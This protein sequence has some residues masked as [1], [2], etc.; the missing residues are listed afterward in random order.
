VVAEQFAKEMSVMTLNTFNGPPSFDGP[1]YEVHAAWNTVAR[2]DDYEAAQA[3]V[4]R[5]SDDGFP[6]ASLS[7]V[8]NGLRLVE[9]VTGRLTK[10]KAAASGAASGAWF[11]VLI[12]LLLTMFTTG[13]AVLSLLAAGVLFGAAWGALFGFLA[14]AATRGR[15]DFSAVRSLAA[16]NYD[17]IATPNEV[18]RARFMLAKAGLLPHT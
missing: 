2:Y 12:G 6:V 5:L 13:N 17:L 10:A 18:D 1:Q 4:D 9:R 15:R 3:A 7:I 11:G 16:Q 14:H 8:G